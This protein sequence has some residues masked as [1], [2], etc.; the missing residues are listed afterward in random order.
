[1]RTTKQVT[2]SEP[3]PIAAL[4]A[5]IVADPSDMMRVALKCGV[6]VDGVRKWLKNGT[7]PKNRLVREALERF[8]QGGGK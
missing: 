8:L 7:L 4:R 5:R 3:P 1:M 6:T 2:N